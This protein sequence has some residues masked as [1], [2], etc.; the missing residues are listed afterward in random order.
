[1]P[2]VTWRIPGCVPDP[3]FLW[4]L[5]Y[6]SRAGSRCPAR[7]EHCLVPCPPGS[8]VWWEKRHRY[9]SLTEHLPSPGLQRA[10]VR[11]CGGLTSAWLTDA[12]PLG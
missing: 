12:V 3:A 4:H 1:M 5:Q 6:S 11:G 2:A 8:S 10:Q 7:R 9:D